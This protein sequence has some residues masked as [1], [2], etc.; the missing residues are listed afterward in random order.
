MRL[1][2]LLAAPVVLAAQQV[3]PLWPGVA[4]GS[5]NWTH[6][7]ITYKNSRTGEMM[8]RDIVKPA[9][10]AYLP[11]ASIATGTAIIIAPGGGFRFLSWDSEGVLVAKWLQQR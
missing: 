5:E 10:T 2:L 4:P 11:D 1:A 9:I 8:I 3:I 7:E 6:Q